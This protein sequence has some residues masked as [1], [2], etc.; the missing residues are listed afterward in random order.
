MKKMMAHFLFM[1]SMLSSTAAFANKPDKV[2]HAVAGHTFQWHWEQGAFKGAAY[3]VSFLQDGQL[4]W[5]GIAGG[6]IG[7]HD[8]EKQYQSTAISKD[9]RMI[10]WLEKSGYAITII[11]NYS[12][13]SC[14]G[15]V[16]NNNEW[17]PL[18]GKFKQTD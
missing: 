11:L 7:K 17:Y 1:V 2:E 10:S 18:S 14:Q 5:Q 8:T 13:G 4:Q 9:I 6:V 15:I 3:Q 12:D 16:S